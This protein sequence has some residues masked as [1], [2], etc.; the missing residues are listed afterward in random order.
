MN[1][2]ETTPRVIQRYTKSL[3]SSVTDNGV[4]R[5]II[6]Y[7]KVTGVQMHRFNIG[8]DLSHYL[9]THQHRIKSFLCIFF[10]WPPCLDAWLVYSYI[11]RELQSRRG[12]DRREKMIVKTFKNPNW[13]VATK[14]F[15][16]HGDP[17]MFRFWDSRQ[18]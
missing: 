9:Y 1:I 17:F 18:R 16:S 14:I 15:F 5:L 3:Q 2:P 8:L 13:Q 12:C 4:S 10:L 11:K 7:L 6:S